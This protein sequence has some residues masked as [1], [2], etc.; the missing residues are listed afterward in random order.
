MDLPDLRG[1]TALVTGAGRGIGRATARR[2]AQSGAA[3]V[4]TARGSRQIDEAAA[5]IRDGGGE[6]SAYALDIAQGEEVRRMIEQIGG[7]DILVNN[8]G[9]IEP[10]APIA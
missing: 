5:E 7:V 3:V 8:A 1:R 10:I 4:L 2:L 9:V 6:A